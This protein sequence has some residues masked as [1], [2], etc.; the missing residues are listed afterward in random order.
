MVLGEGHEFMSTNVTEFQ[1]RGYVA[2]HL[3]T[4]LDAEPTLQV[5]VLGALT[6]TLADGTA[7]PRAA[8]K[9]AKNRHLLRILAWQNGYPVRCE[10]LVEALWP[11]VRGDRGRASLRTSASFLRRTL[12]GHVVREADALVLRNADVDVT[13]FESFCVRTRTAFGSGDLAAGLEEADAA[14]RLYRGELSEDEPAPDLLDRGA[15]HL[16]RTRT[17]LCLESADVCLRLGRYTDAVRL[18]GEV[19]EQDP[20]CERACRTLMRGYDRLSE[21]TMALR[22]FD[23]CR[24][25]LADELGIGASA[26]TQSIFTEILLQD[27]HIVA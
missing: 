8:F 7:V 24:R 9:T 12:G 11:H 16:A 5:G 14:L 3:V 10:L 25:S 18:A 26:A 23:R 20:C 1:R 15:Q 2:P 6:V 13:S 27:D 4:L 19:F 21:R 22:S 17:E